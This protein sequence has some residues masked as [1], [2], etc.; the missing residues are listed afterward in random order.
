MVYQENYLLSIIVQYLLYGIPCIPGMFKKEGVSK[1]TEHD[2]F[3]KH[4][5][6]QGSQI[7]SLS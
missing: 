3:C 6:K 5:M 1:V 4:E 7:I 2:C